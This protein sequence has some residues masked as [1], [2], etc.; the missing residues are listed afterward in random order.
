MLEKELVDMFMGTLQGPYLDRLIGS[1][2]ASFSDLV[3]AGEWIEN[4]LKTGKIQGPTVASNGTKKS[5][6]G[7]PKKKEGETNAASTSKGKGK[8]YRAPYYQVVE[9]TPN[10]YQQLTYTILAVPKQVPYQQPIQYHQSYAPRQNNY[11]QYQP[12]QQRP[13]RQERRLD[14]LPMS[15]S[16]LLNHILNG[17]LIKLREAKPPSSPLPPGY[18]ANARCEFHIGAPVHTIDNCKAF[19]DKFQDL[20]D[21]KAISSAPAGPN[22]NNNLMPPHAG[23]PVNMIQESAEVDCIS[24]VDMIKTLLLEVKE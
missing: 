3:V 12:G 22:V 4:G 1:T 8:A 20:L 7:F 10:N 2:S 17:S 21:S 5:Y 16:Q 9:V 13:R 23:H 14:P 6:S 19:L 18:D 11:Q 24:K 15:C